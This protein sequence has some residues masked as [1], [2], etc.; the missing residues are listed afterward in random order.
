MIIRPAVVEDLQNCGVCAA[1][2]YAS[3]PSLRIFELDRFVSTWTGLLN[4]GMAVLFLLLDNDQ[5]VGAIGGVAHQELYSHEMVCAELFWHVSKSYRGTGGVR[6]FKL[7][8]Q[9][10]IEK[11]CSH[12]R[13]A[14]LSESMPEKVANF[15]RRQNFV[16]LETYFCKSLTSELR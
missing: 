15:Y 3:A 2:F 8:E 1:E 4:S 9:W 12:L 14:H 16:P 6:L 13:M 11:G 10:A 5:I 7:L